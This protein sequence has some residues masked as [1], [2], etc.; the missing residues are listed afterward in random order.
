[1]ASFERL[2]H[3]VQPEPDNQTDLLLTSAPFGEPLGWRQALLFSLRRRFGLDRAPTIFTMVH[4]TAARFQGLISH[5]RQALV[6]E[7]PEPEDFEFPGLAPQAYNVLIEQGRRGGPVLALE[8][9]V[10]A[11]TKSINALLLVGDDR[12]EEAYLFNLVGAHPRVPFTDPESAYEDL[13]LRMVTTASTHE[14]T[15]HRVEGEIERRAWDQAPTPGAMQR[16]ALELGAR[17]FFT[18]M[19]RIADLVQV[20]ALDQVVADQYSEGCFATW[21]PALNGLVAT[22]TGSAR[23]VDKANLSEEDLALIVGL[24]PDGNGAVVC[25][26]QGKVNDPPSSEAVEMMEMDQALPRVSLSPEWEVA[27]EVP[28]VRSKLHGHRGVAAYNPRVVEHVHLDPA[29]YHF[30]VSCSTHAQ[31]QAI[32]DAFADAESLQD[33]EDPRGLAFALL[34]GHGIV[35]VEKWIAGKAPFEHIWGAM[36]TGD[37]EISRKIPQ[38][39]FTYKPDPDGRMRLELL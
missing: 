1:M 31:A 7:P 10:Q 29:Y 18:E 37:L 9:L 35:V 2:G 19:V 6:K 11:Q 15:D 13:V 21:D 36:D 17:E 30:P 22:V 33:P 8:R 20:P 12:P 32:R 14:V 23:P 34:P 27:A 28:V 24:Q 16:A 4:T 5:F 38:G 25:H 3:E 26:V 39:P